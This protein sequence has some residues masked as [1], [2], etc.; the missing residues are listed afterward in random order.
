M[1]K[2][3]AIDYQGETVFNIRFFVEV[4]KE[5][6]SPIWEYKKLAVDFAPSKNMYRISGKKNTW[7]SLTALQGRLDNSQ[8]VS[9]AELLLENRIKREGW[10]MDD[11]IFWSVY[12]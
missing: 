3:S 1:K 6:D 11:T 5:S 2:F 4:R 8:V 7:H 10:D 12:L 9:K